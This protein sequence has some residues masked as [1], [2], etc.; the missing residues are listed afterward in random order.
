MTAF[1]NSFPS[2]HDCSA[3]LRNSILPWSSD[4]EAALRILRFLSFRWLTASCVSQCWLVFVI[5]FW[6]YVYIR[7]F[8][9][10]SPWSAIMSMTYIVILFTRQF[11]FSVTTQCS[12]LLQIFFVLCLGPLRYGHLA[13]RANSYK[14]S[15]QRPSLCLRPHL[16][17]S[18]RSIP[19]QLET[20]TFDLVSLP[21]NW[22]QATIAGK[23]QQPPHCFFSPQTLK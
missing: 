15:K 11:F 1:R 23:Q 18:A 17:Y 2:T 10:K 21:Q 20:F 9:L 5:W 13:M 4:L 3:G 22:G 7:F 14:P 8:S 12:S 6:L 16:G 19:L